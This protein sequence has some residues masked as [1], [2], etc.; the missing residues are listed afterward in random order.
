MPDLRRGNF[1]APLPSGRAAELVEVLAEGAGLRIDRIV[2][3]GQASPPG[4]W[5]DQPGDEFVVL[6]AGSAVL[7]FEEGDRR[8]DLQPGDWIEIPAHVRHRVEFTQAD[9]P[10]VWL[11]V[12]GIFTA[13]Q[14]GA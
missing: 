5:Y 9:P 4:F 7:R 13:A 3:T 2:S 8:F 6:L 14:A 1:F 11:A 12:H 10:T